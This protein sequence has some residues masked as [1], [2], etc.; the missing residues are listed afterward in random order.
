MNKKA[1][2]LKKMRKSDCIYCVYLYFFYSFGREDLK[3]WK[4]VVQLLKWALLRGPLA[5]L[6]SPLKRRGGCTNPAQA[7]RGL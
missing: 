7:P 6:L 3:R 5:Q 1:D 4:G 2:F